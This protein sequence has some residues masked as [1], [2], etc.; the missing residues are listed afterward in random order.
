[1]PNDALLTIDLGNM[2]AAAFGLSAIP[3]LVVIAAIGAAV[4]L[5]RHWR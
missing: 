2:H 5:S 3:A 4:V 1:M